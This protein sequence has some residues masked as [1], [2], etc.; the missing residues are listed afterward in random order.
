MKRLMTGLKALF[1]TMTRG[2]D[3]TAKQ[4]IYAQIT[5]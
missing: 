5:P 2:I 1:S 3:V 4:E